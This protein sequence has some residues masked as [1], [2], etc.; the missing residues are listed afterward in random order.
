MP[1]C[2]PRNVGAGDPPNRCEHAAKCAIRH[3]IAKNVTYSYMSSPISYISSP[4]YEMSS[5]TR[6]F[7]YVL[8]FCRHVHVTRKHVHVTRKHEHVMRRHV[9][10]TSQHLRAVGSCTRLLSI[11]TTHAPNV[12]Q[13]LL[14]LPCFVFKREGAVWASLPWRLRRFISK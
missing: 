9:H 5:P 2:G 10:V 13:L 8:V 1:V 6:D 3:L 11:Q 14:P 12:R 4:I 7:C